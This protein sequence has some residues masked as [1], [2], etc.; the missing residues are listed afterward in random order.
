MEELI[1]FLTQPAAPST[2]AVLLGVW[3]ALAIA[4]AA[5]LLFTFLKKRLNERR[6]R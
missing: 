4:Y 6:A 3:A 5:L 2:I 1:T